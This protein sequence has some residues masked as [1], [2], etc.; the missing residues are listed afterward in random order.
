[1]VIFKG[2]RK[3][4]EWYDAMPTGTEIEMSTKGSMTSVLFV[5]W[6]KHFQKYRT[7]GIQ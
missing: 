3:N 4:D 1:M 7:P 6:L 5:K 2:I